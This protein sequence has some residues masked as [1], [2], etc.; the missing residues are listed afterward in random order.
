[1]SPSNFLLPPITIWPPAAV[2]RRGIS[3]V[4]PNSDIQP[5]IG[6]EI[7]LLFHVASASSAK[8]CRYT[9]GGHVGGRPASRRRQDL[10][11]PCQAPRG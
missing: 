2:R 4:N 8:P 3:L 9:M 6:F 11:L 10:H 1:L 7:E 5:I